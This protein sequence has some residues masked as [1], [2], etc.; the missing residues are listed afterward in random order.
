MILETLSYLVSLVPTPVWQLIGLLGMIII[1]GVVLV[2]I[3][4]IIMHETLKSYPAFCI[5]YFGCINGSLCL[6]ALIWCLEALG[7]TILPSPFTVPDIIIIGTLAGILL[8]IG[9]LLYN[10]SRWGQCFPWYHITKPKGE[11]K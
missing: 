3:L 9:T 4:Y 1:I 2:G 8:Y 10:K 7:T 11:H 6:A 5:A